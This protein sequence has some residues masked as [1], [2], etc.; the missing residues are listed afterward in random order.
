MKNKILC[1]TSKT[2]AAAAPLKIGR[3]VDIGGSVHGITKDKTPNNPATKS[4]FL[5]EVCLYGLAVFTPR[6]D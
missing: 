5:W 1:Q 3:L 2:L 6:P 4:S